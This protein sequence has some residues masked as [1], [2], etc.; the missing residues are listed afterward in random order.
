MHFFTSLGYRQY[1]ASL[2]AGGFA[3][4]PELSVATQR[5]LMSCGL[6][7][8]HALCLLTDLKKRRALGVVPKKQMAIPTDFDAA[9]KKHLSKQ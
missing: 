8:G 9:R 1:A 6:L 7:E 5:A 4:M 2:A 3:S